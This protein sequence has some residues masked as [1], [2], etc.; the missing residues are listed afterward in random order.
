MKTTMQEDLAELEDA[1]EEFV[2]KVIEAY[3]F[4]WE[5]GKERVIPKTQDLVQK[6]YEKFN[7]E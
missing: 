1:I 7:R 6:I 2:D 4:W 5:T 3:S